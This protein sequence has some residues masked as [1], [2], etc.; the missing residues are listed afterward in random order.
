[1]RA[2][3]ACLFCLAV[4][5]PP[6]VHAWGFDVHRFITRRALDGLPPEIKPFFAAEREFIVEHAVDPDLWR[7]VG[8]RGARGEEDPN[9]YLDIDGLDEPPPFA[10]VP[11]EWEAYVAR[12]GPERANRMGRLPWRADEIYGLLVSRFQEIAKGTPAYAADNARYL[13]AVLAHYVEDAHVPFHAVLNHNGQLTNQHGIHN[14]FETTL[15]MR[16]IKTMKLTPVVVKPFT[17]MRDVIF[18]RLIEGERL[19]E[20]ILAADRQA[21]VGLEFYDDAYYQA[22]AVGALPVASRR[23]SDAASGVASALTSAWIAAGRPQLPTARASA[24]A[25]IRR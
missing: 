6:A 4:L 22:F 5:L 20:Q 8:L 15:V 16:N 11:R 25:R 9:H 21:I 19:V 18:D 12:Y 14:R 13:A 7:V 1:M 24:P 2:I 23:V 10:S 3:A 17:S